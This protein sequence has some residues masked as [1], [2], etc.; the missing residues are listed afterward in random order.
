MKG[1]LTR[2]VR[3]VLS[4]S[5]SV[6]VGAR[7][8]AAGNLDLSSH[9]AAVAALEQ[10]AAS[11]QELS[12]TVTRNAESAAPPSSLA[13]GGAAGDARG[14]MV[15]GVVSTMNGIDGSAARM[16]EMIGTIDGI[17]FQTNI[18][19]LNAAVRRARG[20]QGRGFA[21]WRARCARSR[22]AAPAP[23]ARSAR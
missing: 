12:V 22:S 14:E 18:L 7:Q 4:S 5:D 9:R 2:T 11:M 3:Q 6:N 15:R 8:I 16:A 19:A 13:G 17:A 21:W 10:T 1:G 20:E 23:R